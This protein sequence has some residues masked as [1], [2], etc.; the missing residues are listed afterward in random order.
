[1]AVVAIV[2][3]LVIV[4]GCGWLW[5]R[6]SSFVTVKRVRVTGLSGPNVPQIRSVLTN[7]ALEMTTLDVS[8]SQLQSAVEPYPDV[9]SI[10]VTTHFPHGI[11]IRVV[12]NIPVAVATVSGQQVAIDGGG[13]VL[14][15]RRASDGVLPSLAAGAVTPGLTQVRSPGTLAALAVLGSAPYALLAHIAQAH[16]TSAHGVVVELRNGPQLYFGAANDLTAKWTAAVAVLGDSDSAPAS[17]ID[18]SDPRR[19]AAGVP[20]TGSGANVTVAGG[21]GSPTASSGAGDSTDSGAAA[22]DGGSTTGTN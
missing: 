15:V 6:D 20:T 5:F 1:M 11:V 13:T 7:A 22:D 19:P 10:S 8:M 4:L 18:V 16:T 17:Y 21:A 3:G 9:K 14:R 12:E 2:I